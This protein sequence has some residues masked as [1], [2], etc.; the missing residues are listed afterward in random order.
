[1]PDKH[2]QEQTDYQH[3]AVMSLLTSKNDLKL[4]KT[5][6]SIIDPPPKK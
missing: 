5:R 1:M 3:L 6:F 4:R 2:G